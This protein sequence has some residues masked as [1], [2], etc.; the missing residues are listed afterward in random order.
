[1]ASAPILGVVTQG[2]KVFSYGKN[3]E[4][5]EQAVRNSIIAYNR[6][7]IGYLSRAAK[8]IMPSTTLSTSVFWFE[9]HASSVARPAKMTMSWTLPR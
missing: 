5:D 6:N 8:N 2:C 3:D 9:R 1:M 4:D 7:T